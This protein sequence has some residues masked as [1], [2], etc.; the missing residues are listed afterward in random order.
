M[1]EVI[2]SRD[3]AH[4]V[5]ANVGMDAILANDLVDDESSE[6]VDAAESTPSVLSKFKSW[7]A[8]IKD[9][10]LPARF[11]ESREERAIRALMKRASFYAPKKSNVIEICCRAGHP[12]LAQQMAK[13]WTDAFVEEQLRVSRTEGSLYFFTRQTQEIEDRLLKAEEDLKE[14]KSSSGLVSIEGQRQVLEQQAATIRS[15]FLTNN[16]ML[17]ASESKV[18]MLKSIFESLPPTQLADQTTAESHQGWN[19]LREKLF[20]LQIRE[21]E[22][23][24]KYASANPEVIAVEQQRQQVEKVLASQSK[25]SPEAIY[26]PNPTYQLFQQ[27]LLNEQAQTVALKAE[28]QSLEKQ[29]QENLVELKKLNE[30]TLLVNDLERQRQILETSYLNSATRLEQATILQALE[31]ANISSVSELQ[32]ASFDAR[33]AGLGRFKTLL[34]G[35]ILG[36]ISGLGVAGIAEYFDRSFVT[37]SQ[38]ENTLEL[39]VL[40]SVPRGRRQFVE[41]N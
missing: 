33:P 11:D 16:S 20:E 37:S 26:G 19:T 14:A 40:V 32:R 21:F 12:K 2:D 30:N 36:V 10:A 18:E 23:K 15:R 28:R 17:A 39:P 13:S 25:S 4:R 9:K 31:N 24:S 34:L 5:L 38:V 8:A 7:L 27:E 35:L 6:S 1:L 29:I 22:L 41:V 3:T